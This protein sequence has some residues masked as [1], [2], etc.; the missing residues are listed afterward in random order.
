LIQAFVTTAGTAD[1]STTPDAAAAVPAA[2]ERERGAIAALIREH[3]RTLAASEVEAM[4]GV[5]Y[6]EACR[7]GIDPLLVASIVAQ[8]S[9]FR[10]AVISPVGAIG[11]M[12]I[13]P[14]V[15]YDVARRQGIAWPGSKALSTAAFNVRLGILYYKELAT[16]FAG[17]AVTALAAYN[18]G[19]T[20]VR[21]QIADGSFARPAYATRILDR[22]EQLDSHRETLDAPACAV[23]T[24]PVVSAG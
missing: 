2:G 3:R 8:E 4:T 10:E 16:H 5:I 22:F 24:E 20:R 14:E 11:L 13:R 9:S 15:A 21:R 6:D 23:A 17:D 12:Q 1:V 7:A 18:H 19:P